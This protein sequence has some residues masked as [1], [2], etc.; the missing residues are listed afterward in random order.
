MGKVSRPG[1][2]MRMVLTWYANDGSVI[3]RVR[4][5]ALR[6]ECWRSDATKDSAFGIHPAKRPLLTEMEINLF[7]KKLT[8]DAGEGMGQREQCFEIA[9]RQEECD[10]PPDLCRETWQ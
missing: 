10:F 2:N 7:E 4:M 5:S 9:T 1:T 3:I 6:W 8:G